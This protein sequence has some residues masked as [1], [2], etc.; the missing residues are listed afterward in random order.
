MCVYDWDIISINSAGV[1]VMA[2]RP[3]P[4]RWAG[5]NFNF[6]VSL[7]VA[8]LGPPPGNPDNATF[9]DAAAQA[10]IAQLKRAQAAK[11]A[12]YKRVVAGL[13][14]QI[15]DL[16]EKVRSL[17]VNDGQQ[18]HIEALQGV[19]T[20]LTNEN[21]TQKQD[22]LAQNERMYTLQAKVDAAPAGGQSN[23][24][25]VKELTKRVKEL[26]EDVTRRTEG[27]NDL[28][29]QLEELRNQNEAMENEARQAK[30][31]FENLTN[32]NAVKTS[33]LQE[34][35]RVSE[36]LRQQIIAAEKELDNLQQAP[37]AGV[38]FQQQLAKEQ[39]NSQKL[40]REIQTL[41]NQVTLR[42]AEIEPMKETIANLQ[43]ERDNVAAKTMKKCEAKYEA[44]LSRSSDALA[45]LL[46]ENEQMR[47][48]LEQ[49]PPLS[50][51][52]EMSATAKV[53]AAEAFAAA[54]PPKR[55]TR[56]Q[57]NK[58]ETTT[59][60]QSGGDMKLK[61]DL[62]VLPLSTNMIDADGVCVICGQTGISKEN[63]TG[64]ETRKT[65]IKNHRAQVTHM[66]NWTR[67]L[68]GPLAGR[69]WTCPIC[70]HK[71][72]MVSDFIQHVRDKH[73][74]NFVE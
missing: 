6:P 10:E 46:A 37:E 30:R 69:N 71:F 57:A 54:T 62:L 64:E 18:D 9:T 25:Q 40:T 42:D 15:A 29:L 8:A 33:E 23:P 22:L 20:A 27:Y 26:T 70:P 34:A 50:T 41:R 35:K 5:A 61:R 21:E 38:D 60:S 58:A 28:R 39:K 63:L 14:G 66:D 43:A 19:I 44:T 12:D 65:S 7:E 13:Q 49:D 24:D 72:H 17:A 74:N 45:K 36:N 2:R 59:F 48:Q 3:P 31:K 1:A 56:L 32:E 55:Q 51:V 52:P 67:A 47:E 73:Y 16:V 11:D 68:M 53:A 4:F